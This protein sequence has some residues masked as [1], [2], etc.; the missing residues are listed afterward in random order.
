[1]SCCTS[2]NDLVSYTDYTPYLQMYVDICI[3]MYV[4]TYAR[5]RERLYTHMYIYI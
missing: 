4:Y 2:L 1:V 5:V 3:Y